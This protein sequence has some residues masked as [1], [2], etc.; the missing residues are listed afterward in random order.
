MM[1]GKIPSP[2]LRRLVYPHLPRRPDLLVAAAVGEDAAI[3]DFGPSVCVATCDPITGAVQHLGR[4]AVHV[5]CNDIAATGAEPVALLLTLLLPPESREE[6]IEV[7][8]GEA[9]RA[10]AAMGVA[11]AGGHTEITPRVTQPLVVVAGIGRAGRQEYVHAGGAHPGESVLLT[12]AAAIEGTAI[13]ATD[14]A[15]DLAE[16][17]SAEILERARRFIAEV[18]VVPEGRIAAGAGATA[19]HDVTEGGVLTAAWELGEASG[20][21][22]ELWA[23]AVPVREE[24]AAICAAVGVDPLALIGSGAM[25]IT[26]ADPR[27][28]LD[29]LRR[30]G[31]A[32]AQVGAM[33]T[34]GR[35]L[36]RRGVEEPLSPPARDELWRVLDQRG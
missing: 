22:V 20:C 7:I 19:M 2:L 28:T 21:G 27:R 10:A 13:L 31:I 34:T 18:S 9:G 30:G 14:L 8:M 23:D 16:R 1:P 4:L 24:T 17:V 15:A 25:L 35:V 36:R 29:A 3:L 6:A 32:V 12:K 5:A 26:T 11:I 33:R